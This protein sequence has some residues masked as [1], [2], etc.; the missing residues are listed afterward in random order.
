M[1]TYA[2]TFNRI[3][4]QM[5]ASGVAISSDEAFERV[6]KVLAPAVKEAGEIADAMGPE[7]EIVGAGLEIIGEVL[8]VAAAITDLV[9]AISTY[10]RDEGLDP[11]HFYISFTPDANKPQDGESAPH[12]DGSWSLFP[13]HNVSPSGGKNNIVLAK[14]DEVSIQ[15]SWD[16][17]FSNLPSGCAVCFWCYEKNTVNDKLLLTFPIDDAHLGSFQKTIYNGLQDCTYYVDWSVTKQ[18]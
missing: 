9:E 16:A 15:N 5:P 3:I 7:G 2:I 1:S 13:L 17:C 14:G 4:C 18:D 6:E 11:D 10:R 12:N 8:E